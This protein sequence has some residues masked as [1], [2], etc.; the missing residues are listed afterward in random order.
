[1]MVG[2]PGHFDVFLAKILVFFSRKTLVWDVFMSLYLVAIEG[3]L[4]AK[5]II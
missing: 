1:M 4:L 5:P 3:E 2:Y